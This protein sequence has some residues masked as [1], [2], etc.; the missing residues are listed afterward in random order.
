MYPQPPLLILAPL[1][2]EFDLAQLPW[3]DAAQKTVTVNQAKFTNLDMVEVIVDAMPFL[4]TRLTEE[5]TSAALTL[6]PSDLPIRDFPSPGLSAIG[7]APGA[8]LVCARH[9]PESHRRLLSLGRWIGQSLNA[10]VA[11]WMPSGKLE[12]FASYGDMVERYLSEGRFPVPF[13]IAVAKVS[14]GRFRTKGLSHF[15]GQEIRLTVPPDYGPAE[16]SDR[17]EEIVTEL[18]ADGR[19]DGPFRSKCGVRPETLI[20]APGDDPDHVE[21]FIRRD[22]QDVIAAE[23]QGR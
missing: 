17:V 23:E 19:I 20:Y 14:G 1:A 5:E 3:C 2:D 11:A 7:V 12:G 4:L 16:I 21:M 9:V 10:A 15:T 22:A 6:E 13:H 8:N 18:V